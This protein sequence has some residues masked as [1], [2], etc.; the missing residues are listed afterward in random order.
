MDLVI[1]VMV[2][3]VIVAVGRL[4]AIP[5]DTDDEPEERGVSPHDEAG[6]SV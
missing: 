5:P 3:V 1:A 4:R 2:V 6:P